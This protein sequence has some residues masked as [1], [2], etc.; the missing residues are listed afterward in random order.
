MRNG[1][2]SYSKSEIDKIY[3]ILYKIYAKDDY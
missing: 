1:L 3:R 2:K